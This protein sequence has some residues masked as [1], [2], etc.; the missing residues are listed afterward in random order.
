MKKDPIIV[1]GLSGSGTRVIIKILEELNAS[2]G[3]DVNVSSDDLSF[4]L[5]FKLP[6]FYKKYF[7]ENSRFVQKILKVHNKLLLNKPLNLQDWKYILKFSVLHLA[8]FRRYNS[9]WILSRIRSILFRR[10]EPIGLWGWK[11]PHT[12]PFISD[13]KTFYPNARFILIIRNGLDMVFSNNDQQFYNYG[14][15]F[16][17]NANDESPE[18]RFEFWYRFNKYALE[19]GQKCFKDK[20]IVVAYEKIAKLEPETI[21]RIVNFLGHSDAEAVMSN[22]KNK[23]IPQETINRYQSYD[24]TWINDEIIHKCKE[25]EC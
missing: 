7:N 17:I 9:I 11:E 21:K 14:D 6:K 5:L 19:I 15:Y 4:T 18:N 1:S 24:T 8:Q 23:I 12:I 13:I 22:L 10:V 16:D 20:F 2:F 3:Y 25:L